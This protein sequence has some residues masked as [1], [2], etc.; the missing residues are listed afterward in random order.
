MLD[1]S[2]IL[3]QLYEGTKKRELKGLVFYG[4]TVSEN[5][6]KLHNV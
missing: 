3:D 2:Y 5:I 4:D 6:V 1:C